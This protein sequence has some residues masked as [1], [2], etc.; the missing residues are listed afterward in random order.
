MDAAF[1]RLELPT[2][3]AAIDG[4]WSQVKPRRMAAMGEVPDATRTLGIFSFR[5]MISARF[6]GVFPNMDVEIRPGTR[7]RFEYVMES[8]ANTKEGDSGASLMDAKGV[9]FGLHFY[10][11]KSQQFVDGYSLA[12]PIWSIVGRSD[13]F[14][15]RFALANPHP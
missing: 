14:G 10:G 7:V 4:F 11:G 2:S 9:I 6:V 8:A 12:I 5:G 1:L 3:R 13:Y 15:R